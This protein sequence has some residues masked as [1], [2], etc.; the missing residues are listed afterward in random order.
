MPTVILV[1]CSLGMAERFP[2]MIKQ[3]DKT[4]SRM[5]IEKRSLVAKFIESLTNNTQKTVTK[6]EA[7][8]LVIRITLNCDHLIHS[9]SFSSF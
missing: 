9:Y 3:D 6:L 7:I 8:A 5:N 1:D 4:E 2:F